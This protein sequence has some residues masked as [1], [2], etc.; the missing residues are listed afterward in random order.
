MAEIYEAYRHEVSESESTLMRYFAKTLMP[1]FGHLRPDQLSRLHAKAYTKLRRAQGVSDGTIGRELG[2]LRASARW[3]NKNYPTNWFMPPKP[4]PKDRSLSRE[5]FEALIMASKVP[6]VEL[7]ILLALATGARTSAIL[8]LTWSQVCFEK[9]TINFGTGATNKRRT[10]VPINQRA[11]EALE[12]AFL[13]KSCE[14]VIEYGS[15]PVKSIKKGFENTR[16]RAGLSNDVTPHTLR[17][18]AAV[19]MAEAGISMDEIAQYLG[20]S[21]SRITYQVYARYSPGYLQKAADVL[22]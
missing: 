13:F 22:Q 15:K 14:H 21:T 4:P 20:H 11:T 19:W 8:Q 5:E 18:T 16:K 7:F 9:R 12:R 2:T 3:F 10:Q 17:H 1:H 6:H